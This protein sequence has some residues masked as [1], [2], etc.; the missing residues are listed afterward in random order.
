MAITGLLFPSL[1]STFILVI[2][3]LRPPKH[4]RSMNA[5]APWHER[6]S[7]TRRFVPEDSMHA[8]SA[9]K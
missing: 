4:S 9:S 5:I 8:S 3:I 1:Q 2:R 7:W 6:T